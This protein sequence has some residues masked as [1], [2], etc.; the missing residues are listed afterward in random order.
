MSDLLTLIK[1]LSHKA[2][3]NTQTVITVNLT[4]ASAPRKTQSTQAATIRNIRDITTVIKVM[5]Q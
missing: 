1:K 5:V 2:N 4:F 3:T